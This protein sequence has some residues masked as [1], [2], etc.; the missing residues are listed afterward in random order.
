MLERLP[1]ITLSDLK[2]GDTI[3]T[4]TSAST[5]QNRITAIKLLSGVEAFL[6]A[7]QIPGGGRGGQGGGSGFSIP[8]L[9]SGFGF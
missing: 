7:P 1:K 8:G 2:V 5:T 4:L 6:N 3:G 9:D